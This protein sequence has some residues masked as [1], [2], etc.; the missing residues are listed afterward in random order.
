MATNKIVV[1]MDNRVQS[2]DQSQ[3]E[4]QA[5]LVAAG[6]TNSI[7][8]QVRDPVTG[9]LI[10]VTLTFPDTANQAAIDAVNANRGVAAAT[11]ALPPSLVISD[12]TGITSAVVL[13]ITGA[14]SI[15][16]KASAP[17]PSFLPVLGNLNG[18]GVV[19]TYQ[20]VQVNP[21]PSLY[22][23]GY[24]EIVNQSTIADLVFASG[25]IVLAHPSGPTPL[26]TT[27]PLV[28]PKRVG[29]DPFRIK[30]LFI[31]M[32]GKL[33]LRQDYGA[34]AYSPVFNAYADA[35]GNGAV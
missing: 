24:L 22:S 20:D 33:Y 4:I 21:D 29:A 6:V 15:S 13:S 10:Q 27:I 25:D 3:A 35:V 30:E 8:E 26:V 16:I 1:G 23:V 28:I 7:A 31:G 9:K 5:A 34:I 18:N 32:D 17:T 19:N 11:P 12:L 14:Q 2:G